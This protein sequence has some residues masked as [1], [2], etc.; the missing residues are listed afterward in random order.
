MLLARPGEDVHCLELVGGADVGSA[1]GPVLDQQARRA[2]ERR[3]RDLQSDIDDARAANDPHRAERAEAELDALVQ[4]LSE[5]FGLSGR[6]RATGSATE[7][8]RSA[9]GWRIRAA[10]RQVAEAHPLLGRHLQNAVRTGT[11]CSYRPETPVAWTIDEAQG[12][13]A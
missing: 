9:V 5:A 12:R 3:I 6:S 11:W 7:R 2:Y 8:A 4:Q 1:P 13:R 10:L